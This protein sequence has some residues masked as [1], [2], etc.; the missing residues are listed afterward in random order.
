MEGKIIEYVIMASVLG[1]CLFFALRF[2]KRTVMEG[3]SCMGCSKNGCSSKKMEV[4]AT[5]K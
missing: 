1:V 2:L 4:M 3:S 5:A